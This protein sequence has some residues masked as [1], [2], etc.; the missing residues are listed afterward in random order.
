[1]DTVPEGGSTAR[2]LGLGTGI[3]FAGQ[4]AAEYGPVTGRANAAFLGGDIALASPALYVGNVPTAT[5]STTPISPAAYK[6]Y[7]LGGIDALPVDKGRAHWNN[8]GGTFPS[9]N[10]LMVGRNSFTGGNGVNFFWFDNNGNLR[11]QQA[12]S[13]AGT[14]SALLQTHNVVG[15]DV[16][17]D[18]PPTSG[19]AGLFFAITEQVATDGGQ[20]TYS[21]LQIHSQ[22]LT[23]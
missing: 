14:R 1:L 23:Q 12:G 15:V 5:F 20:S 16:T 21:L 7:V 17:F 19:F 9:E 18:G 11:S 13:D 8:F 10:V 3:D 2:Q 4:L 6:P 22:C